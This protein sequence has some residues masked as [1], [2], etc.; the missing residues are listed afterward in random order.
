MEA[1]GSIVRL[2]NQDAQTPHSVHTNM[3]MPQVNPLGP[4]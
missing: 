4:D 3:E 1:N 2:A